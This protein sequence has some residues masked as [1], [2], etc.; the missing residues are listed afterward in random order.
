MQTSNN[1]NYNYQKTQLPTVISAIR[2]LWRLS[3]FQVIWRLRVQVQQPSRSWRSTKM[4]SGSSSPTWTWCTEDPAGWSSEETPGSAARHTRREPRH[5]GPRLGAGA[6][7]TRPP[8]AAAAGPSS[9]AA[10]TPPAGRRLWRGGA[11]P[12]SPPAGRRRVH[13]NHIDQQH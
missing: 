12:R 6:G 3:M 5:T 11:P 13:F 2:G 9:T 7:G 1:Q 10:P 4:D 8:A